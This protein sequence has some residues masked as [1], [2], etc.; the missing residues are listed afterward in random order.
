MSRFSKLSHVIWHR[1]Y[2]VV[3]A[4]DTLN[5]YNQDDTEALCAIAA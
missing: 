3:F 2:H 5:R 1:K 4:K